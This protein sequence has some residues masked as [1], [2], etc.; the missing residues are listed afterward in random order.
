MK[1]GYIL[2]MLF[3][4]LPLIHFAVTLDSMFL[5]SVI[6]LLSCTIIYFV[7]QRAKKWITE[8]NNLV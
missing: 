3:S 7:V 5:Y 1:P 4:L 8:F 2:L 6:N